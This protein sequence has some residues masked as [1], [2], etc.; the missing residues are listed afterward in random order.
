M[1]TAYLAKQSS[2]NVFWFWVLPDWWIV[3]YPN[4]LLNL[5][6]W[7]FFFYQDL[8]FGFGI[9][10]FHWV[11]VEVL[12]K[13]KKLK[14]LQWSS[15]PSIMRLPTFSLPLTSSSLLLAYS[16]PVMWASP[17]FLESA[18]HAL[19][20]VLWP[21]SLFICSTLSPLSGYIFSTSFNGI[22][23]RRP[24]LPTLFNTPTLLLL[25]PHS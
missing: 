25:S 19:E 2:L 18:K 4:K 7:K 6:C 17:L 13:V 12:T 8:L 9:S 16:I 5:F 1:F 15:K 20:P 22:F 3:L 21:F 14:S 24:G 10:Q 23:S 11:K